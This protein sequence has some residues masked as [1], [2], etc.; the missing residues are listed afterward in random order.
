MNITHFKDLLLKEEERLMEGMSMIGMM[1]T[2]IKGDWVVHTEATDETDPNMVADKMEEIETN[3][4]I[5][6]TLE[7]RMREV[8]EAMAR[9]EAGTYGVCMI[10][11]KRIEDMRLEANPA[12]TTCISCNLDDEATEQEGN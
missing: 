11:G 3:E 12:A 4:G 5:L 8:Q 9:I 1:N 2:D 10:C 6:E 7:T